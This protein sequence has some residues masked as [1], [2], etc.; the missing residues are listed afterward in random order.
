MMKKYVRFCLLVSLM[1]SEF[2]L[3]SMKGVGSVKLSPNVADPEYLV[4]KIHGT[5]SI[6]KLGLIAALAILWY[7]GRIWKVDV[8]LSEKV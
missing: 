5:V 8:V 4:E 7:I 2:E 6:L 3:Q 1:S